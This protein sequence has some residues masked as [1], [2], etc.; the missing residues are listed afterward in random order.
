[1]TILKGLWR[2]KNY[3]L[4]NIQSNPNK[5][6]LNRYFYESQTSSDE[7]TAS[8]S[9]HWLQYVW[10]LL[11]LITCAF[12]LVATDYHSD[13]P[14]ARNKRT[15]C[16]WKFCTS[17]TKTDKPWLNSEFSSIQANFTLFYSQR[18]LAFLCTWYCRTFLQSY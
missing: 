14:Y 4:K 10:W 18:Y 3:R 1:M 7:Y 2:F 13:Y 6:F 16:Q 17:T 12:I 11:D 5:Y 8:Q 9:Q 15:L